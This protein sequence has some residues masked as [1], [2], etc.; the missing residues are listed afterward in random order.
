MVFAGSGDDGTRWKGKAC[1]AGEGGRVPRDRL[2]HGPRRGYFAGVID[3][4]MQDDSQGE[5][6]AG[7][8]R[9]RGARGNQPGQTR[10]AGTGKESSVEYPRHDECRYPRIF[11]K[12]T[13]PLTNPPDLLTKPAKRDRH[14]HLPP[15]RAEGTLLDPVRLPRLAVIGSMEASTVLVLDAESVPFPVSF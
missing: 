8:V 4:V 10:G 11:G 13:P 3:R 6:R 7:D 12:D 1:G 2:P 15:E 9:Q 14:R 5:G